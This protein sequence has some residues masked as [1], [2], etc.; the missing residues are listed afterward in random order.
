MISIDCVNLKH[1][2]NKQNFQ[3]VPHIAANTLD[4]SQKLF[5][6]LFI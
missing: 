3:N 2:L 1:M 5:S 6:L 4:N